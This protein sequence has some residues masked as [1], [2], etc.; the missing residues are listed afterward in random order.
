MNVVQRQ[1]DAVA[2]VSGRF[3]VHDNLVG[4]VVV[5]DDRGVED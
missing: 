4:D 1:G 2:A 5:G 3:V